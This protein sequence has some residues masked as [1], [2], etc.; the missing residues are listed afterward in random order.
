MSETTAAAKVVHE[1]VRSYEAKLAELTTD[2][3]ALH[4]QIENLLPGATSAGLASAFNAQKVRFVS[5]ANGLLAALI[6]ALVC[7]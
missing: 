1:M 7:C 5:R 3:Q 2:Y 4:K 6:G